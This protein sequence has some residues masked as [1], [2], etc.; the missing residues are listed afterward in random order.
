MCGFSSELES[1]AFTDMKRVVPSSLA[2]VDNRGELSRE[3]V[4]E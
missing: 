3:E 1:L 4:D 2:G